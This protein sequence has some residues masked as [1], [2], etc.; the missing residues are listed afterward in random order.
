MVTLI[1]DNVVAASTCVCGLSSYCIHH[2]TP[3]RPLLLSFAPC[4]EHDQIRA[5]VVAVQHL[6]VFLVNT[7]A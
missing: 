4:S 1:D 2:I 7:I 6:L 3:A 5:F